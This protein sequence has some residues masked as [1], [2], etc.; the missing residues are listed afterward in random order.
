MIGVYAHDVS[1][2]MTSA[3]DTLRPLDAELRGATVRI[4]ILLFGRSRR[5]HG[6]RRVGIVSQSAFDCRTIK[7]GF[8]VGHNEIVTFGGHFGPN[9]MVLFES[10][11]VLV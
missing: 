1:N 7:I 6:H 9:R 11:A 10:E 3:H 8:A 2:A 4:G 5:G